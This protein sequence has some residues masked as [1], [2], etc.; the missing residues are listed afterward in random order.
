MQKI[1]FIGL[2]CLL[3][4][5]ASA[6]GHKLIPT[7]GTNTDYESALEIQD[8]VVFLSHWAVPGEVEAWGDLTSYVPDSCHG[9]ILSGSVLV[10]NFCLC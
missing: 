8:P 4:L 1:I 10:F 6:F 7:D 2:F 9:H 3:M 5:P